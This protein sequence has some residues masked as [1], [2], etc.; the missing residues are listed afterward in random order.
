MIK[1]DLLRTEI[2][3]ALSCENL[4]YF[5]ANSKGTDQ[6]AM[7]EQCANQPALMRMLISTF[8]VRYPERVEVK[9]ATGKISIFKLLYLSGLT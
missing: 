9:I 6:P 7:I 4:T 1:A 8:V 5:H 2:V 3:W